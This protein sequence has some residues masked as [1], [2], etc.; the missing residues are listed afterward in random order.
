MEKNWYR[1]ARRKIFKGKPIKFIAVM[2]IS[3]R[4]PHPNRKIYYAKG[5]SGAVITPYLYPDKPHIP[6]PSF[7]NEEDL[8]EWLMSTWGWLGIDRGT[9]AQ[10]RMYSNEFSEEEFQAQRKEWVNNRHRIKTFEEFQA[11]DS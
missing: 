9:I 6:A 5:V 8:R 2:V 7:N 3:R 1:E 10:A 11:S 4:P